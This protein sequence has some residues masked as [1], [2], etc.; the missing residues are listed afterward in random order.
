MSRRKRVEDQKSE[1]GGMIKGVK[2]SGGKEQERVI[3]KRSKTGSD[4]ERS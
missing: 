2:R 4:K 1:G 3:R